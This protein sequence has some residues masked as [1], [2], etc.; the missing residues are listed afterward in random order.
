M[1][2]GQV[3]F[4]KPEWG[5][6]GVH[7]KGIPKDKIS[8]VI[9][10]LSQCDSPEDIAEKLQ[11]LQGEQKKKINYLLNDDKATFDDILEDAIVDVIVEGY[12]KKTKKKRE[13]KLRDPLM[14]I[15]ERE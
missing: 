7:V 11:Q 1:E 13:E 2:V 4:S 3:Y 6:K 9:S 14:L 15:K 5:D 12:K 10:F 8:E